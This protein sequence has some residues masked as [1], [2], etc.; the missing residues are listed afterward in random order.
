MKRLLLLT[1]LA[2]AAP[3]AAQLPGDI[4]YN[5][6]NAGAG[7]TLR[8][9]TPST[10]TDL[11][12]LNGSG[13]IT[14]IPQSTFATASHTQAIS[15]I[16]G[17][18]T[19]LDDKASI[20]GSYNDPA[21]LTGL[22]WSKLGSVP[23]AVTALGTAGIGTGVLTG[24]GSAFSYTATSSG[25]N[26][27]SDAGKLA[28]YD[29]FGNIAASL[30]FYVRGP[31]GP[32]AY[33]QSSLS[34]AGLFFFESASNF[35]VLL[36]ATMTGGKYVRIP[37]VGSEGSPATLISNA[38]TGTVTNT[39]LAGSIPLSKLAITGTPDG[40]KY[41]R[42]DGTWQ[43]VSSGATLG[44]NTFTGL[45]QFSGTD[46]AGLRL[47]NLTT[48]QRDALTGSAGMVIWN[49]TAGRMQLH[50]GTAWTAGMVRLDGDTMT[51]ALN[52][53]AGTAT[54][55]TPPLNITQT[56]NGGTGVTHRGVEIAITNTSSNS[57]STLFRLLTG[58]GGSTVAMSVNA[59][60]GATVIGASSNSATLTLQ[61]SDRSAVLGI[62]AFG[63]EFGVS[64]FQIAAANAR[65]RFTDANSGVRYGTIYGETTDV[66]ALRNGSGGTTG[67][68]WE[69]L[70]MTAPGTPAANRARLWIEDNGS[71]KTRLMIQF[72]S[73]AAQ[74]IAIEP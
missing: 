8:Y 13:L 17:L 20:T 73:G 10:S 15:T 11:L 30:A 46:H 38:D 14:R 53:T 59:S 31:S 74:Q 45:Q 42:D 23:A 28:R 63:N 54:S 62:G 56:F 51:G 50:N 7:S 5:T 12:G 37:A 58:A 69:L 68:A 1:L 33:P 26:F 35:T 64:N 70:E 40:T 55:S 21:W 34:T 44:A 19:A 48:T 6:K 47:N 60:T 36:A 22:A 39:M 49:T 57:A 65:L 27:M 67:A 61:G 71:G 2:L 72:G 3:A 29:D 25:G 16:T 18:Q 52:I 32:T 4:L 24:N 41:L 43:T 66:L 9:F